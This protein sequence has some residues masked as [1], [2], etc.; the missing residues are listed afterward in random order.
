MQPSNDPRRALRDARSKRPPVVGFDPH[1]PRVG[2]P[3]EREKV[4]EPKVVFHTP[5]FAAPTRNR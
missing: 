5:Y 1:F 2:Q 4:V 3:A